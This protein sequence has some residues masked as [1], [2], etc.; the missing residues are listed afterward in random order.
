[1]QTVLKSCFMKR[2]MNLLLVD[3]DADDRLLFVEALREVDENIQCIQANN[4]E[5]ALELL[6]NTGNILP[7]CIFLDLR[8]PRISGKKCLT[9]IKGDERLK[10]IPVYIYTTSREV[11]ESKELKAIGAFHFI[12][13]PSNDDEI[14][15]LLAC[16]VEEQLNFNGQDQSDK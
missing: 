13:K 1:M 3:D 4:G 16:A 12:S 5:Q 7:D 14:Y 2:N 6:R 10:H 9:E 11:E 8:M 15:Y